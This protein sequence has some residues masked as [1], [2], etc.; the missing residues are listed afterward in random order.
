MER[1]E[2]VA[3]LVSGSISADEFV[4]EA[5]QHRMIPEP[6][7]ARVHVKSLKDGE[8]WGAQPLSYVSSFL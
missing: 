7:R 2:K 8:C 5:R 6:V 4:D 1:E 3:E